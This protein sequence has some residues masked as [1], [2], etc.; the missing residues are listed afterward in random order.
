[1]E[2]K[3][4]MKEKFLHTFNSLHGFIYSSE[5]DSGF[6]IRHLS[7]A[8]TERLGET[9]FVCGKAWCCSYVADSHASPVGAVEVVTLTGARGPGDMVKCLQSHVGELSPPGPRVQDLA[10]TGDHAVCA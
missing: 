1:L 10:S 6:G 7:L 4:Q 3:T 2:Q 9:L 5:G 8:W